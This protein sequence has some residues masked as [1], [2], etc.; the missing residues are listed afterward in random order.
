MTLYTN[1]LCIYEGMSE[2][3]VISLRTGLGRDTTFVELAE[4]QVI[5]ANAHALGGL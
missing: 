5:L 1:D 4:Y 3:M 2:E